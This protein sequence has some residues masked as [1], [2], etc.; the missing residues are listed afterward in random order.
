MGLTERKVNGGGRSDRANYS[1]KNVSGIAVQG[2]GFRLQALDFR[3][4]GVCL[5][6]GS[7]FRVQC[8]ALC[9]V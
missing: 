6:V 7:G 9:V 4:E 2:L 8:G 5:S 1:R 3:F